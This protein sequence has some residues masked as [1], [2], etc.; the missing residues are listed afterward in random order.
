MI[1]ASLRKVPNASQIFG[2]T[3]GLGPVGR[4]RPFDANA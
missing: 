4:I 3:L 2:E 1:R